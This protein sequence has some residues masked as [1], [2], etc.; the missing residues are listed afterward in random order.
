MRILVSVS[1]KTN[2]SDFLIGLQNI[3]DCEIISTAG[4]S[5]HLL[6]NGISV[7][8]LSDYTNFPEILGGRV[9]SLHPK[10]YGGILFNRDIPDH[11]TQIQELDIKPIDMVIC[12]LYPFQEVIAE[13][14]T[15]LGDAIENIDIGGP[16]MIRAAAKNFESVVVLVDPN[17]YGTVLENLRKGSLLSEAR[18]SLAQKAFQHV[19]NYDSAISNYLNKEEGL[20]LNLKFKGDL[21]YGENPHQKGSI[22]SYELDDSGVVNSLQLNGKEMSYS[23]YLDADS[24]FKVANSF[25]QHC[26]TI[27]KHSNTCGLSQ[28]KNQ[29]DAF[30]AAFEGD[31]LSAFGG[32]VGFNSEVSLDVA[33]LINETFFEI[34]VAPSFN[35]EAL[36][37]LKSK[38]SLRLLK[39]KSSDTQHKS[40]K[41]ISG[42]LIVQSNNLIDESFKFSVVTDKKPTLLELNDINFAWKTCSFIKSNAI[43]LVKDM[44]LVGMGAGQ[45]N[46]LMSVKIA[47]EIAGDDSIGSVLASDAFFPFEDAL[48]Q[49]VKLGIKAVVQPGGSINDKKIIDSANKH[50]ISMVFTGQRRFLH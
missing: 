9:K 49:A 21:R 4:T 43:A 12:N 48:E 13:D 2:I 25:G 26:V 22:Y 23:N 24:A 8:K 45:P 11:K 10:I 6:S 1:D 37:E 27:V 47:G 50:Q 44:T 33:K 7:E 5:S 36:K 38:K 29:L 46:R 32:I 40:I 15:L 16:S 19:S 20:R 31:S 39:V 42:G 30:K 3:E 17:D 28:K 41:S 18:M 34:I 35:P 14:R